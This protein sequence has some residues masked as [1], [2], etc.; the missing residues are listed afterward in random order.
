VPTLVF[1]GVALQRF[2]A[3]GATGSHLSLTH[4]GGFAVA[5][6]VLEG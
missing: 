4:D 5:Y 1:T 3:M 6:V 2:Q